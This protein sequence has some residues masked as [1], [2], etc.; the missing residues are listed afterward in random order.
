ML[1]ASTNEEV[2][3][4]FLNT[5]P[6][7]LAIICLSFL[8]I[9]YKNINKFFI[10]QALTEIQIQKEINYQTIAYAIFI[11]SVSGFMAEMYLSTPVSIFVACCVLY[12]IYLL[13]RFLS[14]E[15]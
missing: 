10:A 5:S 2:F 13:I 1:G 11:S 14:Q 4:I 12:I 6:L 9:L 8:F 7:F 15:K 3:S